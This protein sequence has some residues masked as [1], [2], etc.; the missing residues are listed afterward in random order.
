MLDE[1]GGTLEQLSEDSDEK[2]NPKGREVFMTSS[3][4][5]VVNFDKFK[6]NVAKKYALEKSPASCDALY[7]HSENEWFLIEFAIIPSCKPIGERSKSERP[8]TRRG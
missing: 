5:K 3:Q 6:A 4:K 2:E 8:T 1:F 7:M